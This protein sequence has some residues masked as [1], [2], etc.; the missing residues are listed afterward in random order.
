VLLPELL[1]QAKLDAGRLRLAS[2][3][4]LPGA[5]PYALLYPAH[6]AAIPSFVRLR[7]WLTQQAT[8][9]QGAPTAG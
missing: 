8:G 5:A 4:R 9:G 3:R 6:S 7:D 1:V 2:N